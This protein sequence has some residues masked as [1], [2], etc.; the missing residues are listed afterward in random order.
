MNSKIKIINLSVLCLFI[1]DRIFKSFAL[2]GLTKDFYFIKFF[3][4]LN[5][6]IALG[7]PIK[8]VFFYIATTLII[9]GIIFVLFNSY[10]KNK[11]KDILIFTLILVGAISNLLDRIK[12]GQVVD[13]FNFFAL[14]NF[15]ISD[16]MILTGVVM[17]IKQLTGFNCFFPRNHERLRP[18]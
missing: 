12:Q 11:P 15:N 4:S 1:L 5:P 10:K 13:Y 17:K 16:L 3:L 7:L 9:L 2:A 8:G 6:N 14:I 18:Q